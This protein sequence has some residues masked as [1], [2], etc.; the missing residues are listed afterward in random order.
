MT[1]GQDRARDREAI[2]SKADGIARG[3]SEQLP[4]EERAAIC[5]IDMLE[6]VVL[7]VCNLAETIDAG[8][9]DKPLRRSLGVHLSD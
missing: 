7:A 3:S 6:Q 2:R 8:A 9:P 5:Q 1:A 4:F